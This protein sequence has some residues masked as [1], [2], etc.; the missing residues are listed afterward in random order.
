MHE[1][2]N[3]AFD[4]LGLFLAVGLGLPWAFLLLAGGGG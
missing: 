2:E 1:D 3:D 4:Y